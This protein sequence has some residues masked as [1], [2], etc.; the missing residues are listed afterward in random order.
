MRCGLVR[1]TQ[2]TNSSPAYRSGRYRQP[3]GARSASSNVSKVPIGV[4]VVRLP[5]RAVRYDAGSYEARRAPV[6]RG[7]YVIIE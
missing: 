4:S 1:S 6:A 3:D 2:T 5:D 7:E